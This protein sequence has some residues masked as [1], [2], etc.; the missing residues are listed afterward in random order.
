VGRKKKKVIRREWPRVYWT[1]KDEKPVLC[2]DSRKTGFSAGGRRF[3]HTPAEALAYAEQ[4][5]RTN[6]NEGAAGFAE[7]SITERRDAAQALEVLNGAGSLVEAAIAFMRERERIKRLTHIPTVNEAINAYLTA[8]RAEEEKGEISRLTL[9]E[10]ESKMRIVREAFGLL[11]VTE[12]DE[13]AVSAFIR[14][15]PHAARGKANIRTKLSQFLNYCRREGKWISANPTENIKVRVKNGEVNI[16]S[17]PEV[18]QLLAAARKCELPAS[19]IP[20]LTVQLFAGLRPFEAARLRWERIHFET[21]QIEILGETSKTRETRFVQL[22]PLLSE[23]LLPFRAPAGAITGPFFAETLRAVKVSAGF[24]F[25]ADGD[26]PWPKD[27]LRHCY[28]SYWLAVHKNRAHLAELMGTSLAMIKSHYKRAIPGEVAK[29]F[30]KLTLKPDAPG[31]IID[32]TQ[33]CKVG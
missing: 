20:Y 13:A 1:I 21:M 4:I 6:A 9:Y 18:R 32:I 19:V 5:E 33:S 22:E 26:R 29:E 11:K 23:W 7:L 28:G 8:K 30:W 12:I 24:T 15:L 25:S 14:E 27:V 16:L 17:V 2:V 10:I 31:K 3:W